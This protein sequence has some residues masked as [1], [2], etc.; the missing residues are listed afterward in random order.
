MKCTKKIYTELEKSNPT[1]GY[2]PDGSAITKLDL[3][4]RIKSASMRVKSGD[5]LT[6]QEVE[7]EIDNR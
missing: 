7:K 4:N 6:Q 3:K 5:F 2:N 1:V